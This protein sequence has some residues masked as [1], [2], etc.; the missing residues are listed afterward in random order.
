[1]AT[2][3]ELVHAAT[4]EVGYYAP[5]DPEAGSKYGRWMA[6]VTG[7]DWLS[8]PSTDIWWCCCFVS[9]CL[10]QV[11]Q[12]CPGFP[13]YNTDVVLSANP[14]L[15]LREDVQPGDIIIWDWQG[16]GPTDHIGIVS[17]HKPGEF[18]YLQ[19]IEGNYSNSVA[20][21]D[22]SDCWDLVAAC[23]RPPFSTGTSGQVPM[24]A[25][26]ASDEGAVDAMAQRVVNGDYGNGEERMH[27]I[28]EDVQAAV[29]AMC[30]GTTS[31]DEV[32]DGMAL[33]VMDGTFGNQPD[34]EYNIY[35]AVQTCVNEILG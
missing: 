9:W 21:V 15:V 19:T 16:D 13:S 6:D 7:E 2:A 10:A 11:G 31:G 35:A 22:R 30:E 27:R 12:D 20:V 26:P 3:D 8:G 4:A 28:Y 17:Y 5:N 33:L 23:I 34:R 1:M 14:P 29:N 24:P 18:G 25:V 32:L